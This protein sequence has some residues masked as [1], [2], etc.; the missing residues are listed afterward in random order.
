MAESSH[1]SPLRRPIRAQDLFDKCSGAS[2]AVARFVRLAVRGRS[3]RKVAGAI[4]LKQLVQELTDL[5]WERG[6]S[7]Q[8]PVEAAVLRFVQGA[9][10]AELEY[11]R[12][13]RD[14][15]VIL[16]QDESP[17]ETMSPAIGTPT[18]VSTGL[19]DEGAAGRQP[20]GET[21]EAVSP[22]S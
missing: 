1:R 5:I 4:E 17:E 13:L 14:L 18:M 8:R 7:L 3:E 20:D 19:I 22:A 21:G 12:N 2:G 6:Q 10:A 11:R 16:A 9:V 15:Y